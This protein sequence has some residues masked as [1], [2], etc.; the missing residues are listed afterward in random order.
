M[1]WTRAKGRPTRKPTPNSGEQTPNSDQRTPY[2]S[3]ETPD[4]GQRKVKGY[5]AMPCLSAAS[6]IQATYPND[7][8]ASYFLRGLKEGHSSE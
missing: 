8:N 3:E 4:S 1:G 2:S 5:Q 7:Y 6:S